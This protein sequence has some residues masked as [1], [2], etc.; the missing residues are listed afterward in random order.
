MM[1]NLNEINWAPIIENS[2][3][4]SNADFLR[5]R[6]E[7][8]LSKLLM[9]ETKTECIE[10]LLDEDP[11][12]LANLQRATGFLT[13][14][15]NSPSIEA[16]LAYK[17]RNFISDERWPLT[18]NMFDL[19]DYATISKIKSLR[20]EQNKSVGAIPTPG[21]KGS[22][23]PLRKVLEWQIKQL[24]IPNGKKIKVKLSFD[25]G[26]LTSSKRKKGEL[27]TAQIITD[28]M[29]LSYL[30][31]PK[32]TYLF[33]IYLGDE[34]REVLEEEL[35]D[36][37]ELVN[38]LAEG[39][40]I[41]VDG[42]EYEIDP[43][44]V[45]DMKALVKLQGFYEVY[46]PNSKYK[47]FWCY[48]TKTDMCDFDKECWKMRTLEELI[49]N[50]D[51][52]DACA[53]KAKNEEAARKKFAGAEGKGQMYPPLFRIEP[54][55]VIPCLLHLL[56]AIIK[57]LLTKLIS[58]AECGNTDV[59]KLF[60]QVFEALNLKL[61]KPKKDESFS[62]RASAAR[63][64]RPE[65]LSILQNYKLFTSC[66][67]RLAARG[68][69]E[70][71]MLL[72]WE[73]DDLWE[74]AFALLTLATQER[75][76]ITE[77]EWLD[78]ARPFGK[79]FVKLYHKEDVFPYLHVM[80]YHV[81]Y[82]LSEYNSMEVFSNY[83]IE[84][85]VSVLKQVTKRS[86]PG[87]NAPPSVIALR[88]LQAVTRMRNHRESG[89]LDQYEAN[90][91]TA[92]GETW[93][94]HSLQAHPAVAK[95]V[96]DANTLGLGPNISETTP[97][98]NNDP[99]S[100]RSNSTIKQEKKENNNN[101]VIFSGVDLKNFNDKFTVQDL[102]IINNIFNSNMYKE[103]SVLS[104][105]YNLQVLKHDMETLGPRRWVND[106]I[107]NFY[108]NMIRERNE[109]LQISKI[110]IFSTFFY[111]L[112]MKNDEYNHSRVEGWVRKVDLFEMDKV[113]FPIHVNTDHWV[114]VVV[115][116]KQNRWEFYDSMGGDG[117]CVMVN[118]KKFS[119]LR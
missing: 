55:H 105:K 4:K 6:A 30:K 80:V 46:R 90:V 37:I 93:S 27:G 101:N 7:V 94:V 69:S 75:V 28:D 38:K 9:M 41:V 73:I 11:I 91:N 42:K 8:V 1:K 85:N 19:G 14:H 18:V 17:D 13:K 3:E 98:S 23:I 40:K 106:E 5:Q 119:T 15:L 77:K 89:I 84:G 58:E 100:F 116:F 103:T 12:V 26:Q 54:T 76:T 65:L 82:F 70:E 45:C 113:M 43:Y 99:N 59:E 57:H 20:A 53:S 74:S 29:N 108:T 68:G 79:A 32:N 49:K 48:V 52:V 25:G 34:E 63:F 118:I 31:S 114:L 117:K 115:N 88:Q 60:E 66:L 111:K 10:F 51:K 67:E 107:I 2:M 50:G 21:G 71:Q 86:T 62:D 24:K 102:L 22:Q 16:L 47:C 95:Y 56:M 104:S 110:Y 97:S 33:L 92:R 81:G 64:G 61:P 87:F 83:G 39:E 96:V 78:M 36:C 112:L 72:A 44:L 35:A 109:Q